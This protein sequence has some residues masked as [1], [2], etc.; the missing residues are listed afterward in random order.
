MLTAAI[1]NRLKGDA[2]IF[3]ETGTWNGAGCLTALEVGFQRVISIERSMACYRYARRRFAED[4]RVALHWGDSAHMLGS[5]L[6]GISE[7]AVIW[8]DA[9]R[10]P[11]VPDSHDSFPLGAELHA[12]SVAPY[13]QHTILIDDVDLAGTQ[14][15]PGL[16]QLQ[17]RDALQR[18]NPAYAMW[19]E[20]VGERCGS[21]LVA[22]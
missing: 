22:T 17:I 21:I 1:L 5:V 14:L 2:A 4:P 12:L 13:R 6:A 20:D 9:H 19:L 3:I 16:T 18:I 11:G 10:V 15:L 7:R 8:L